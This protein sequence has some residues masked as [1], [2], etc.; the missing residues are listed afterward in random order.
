MVFA[1]LAAGI[2]ALVGF[3]IHK[4]ADR[5]IVEVTKAI[6]EV[7]IHKGADRSIRPALRAGRPVSSASRTARKTTPRC[8]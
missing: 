7:A 5:S 1:L 2:F 8:R 3:A 6:S 4:G